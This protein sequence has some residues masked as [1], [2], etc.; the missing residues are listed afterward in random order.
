MAG[1]PLSRLPRGERQ[2][3]L[4]DLNYLNIAEIKRFC[5]RHA[6]PF[7]IAVE[8]A[9]GGLRDTAEEDRKGVMLERVRHYLRTG[10]VLEQT[11]FRASVACFE[12]LPEHLAP[13]ERLHYGQYEKKHTGLF[14]IL[15]ELTD[16]HFRDGA[17]ARILMREFWSG[18][19][20]PTLQEF[21]SAWLKASQKHPAPN[22]EWAFLSDR[23]RKTAPKD[24]K[25]MRVDK[26]AKV[27]KILERIAPSR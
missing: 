10:A 26:A 4:D 1:A 21:A 18:G 5:K 9:N 19:T 6:I 13:D 2:K 11:C 27:I 22:Q 3:F 12:P 24:W 17:I 16:G 8:T 25:K 14:A 7:S 15:Q 20:A 23:S